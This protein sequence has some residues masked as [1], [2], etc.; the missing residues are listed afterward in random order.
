MIKAIVNAIVYVLETIKEIILVMILLGVATAFIDYSRM[1]AGK[2]PIFNKNYYNANTKIQTFRGVFYE[3]SR[4]VHISENEPLIDSSQMK[5]S[6]DLYFYRKTLNV[7]VEF[8]KEKFEF[9]LLTQPTLNCQSTSTLYYADENAKFYTYCLDSVKLKE[10]GD[11]KSKD[12]IEYLKKDGSI[13]ED[14]VMNMS[15]VGLAEDGTTQKFKTLDDS[16]VS[17]GLTMYRCHKLYMDDIYI[18]PANTPMQSDFCTYK[19]DDFEWL[20]KVE[21]EDVGELTEEE[22]TPYAFLED[23]I[24]RYEFPN[25]KT[26]D[27]TF[28]T[29]GNIRGREKLQ[30][31]LRDILNTN[32]YTLEEL[33]KR[34]LKYNTINKEEERIRLEEEQRKKEEEER[35]KQEELQ[36]QQEQL[37]QQDIT[38]VE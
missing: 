19:D 28:I 21:Q 13:V 31:P 23:D 2:V 7:P 6:I 30:I 20:W 22:N 8:Q 27:Y 24:N 26:I 10:L 35:K 38:P 14:I 3:A 17:N 15:Y 34:G 12:L 36:K 33:T 9:V 32:R 5:Y 29:R 4:K 16:F 1:S 25:Q 37:E 18:A 11:S